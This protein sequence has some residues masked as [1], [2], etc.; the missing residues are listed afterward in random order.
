MWE[1][2]SKKVLVRFLL[3]PLFAFLFVL[4]LL[5]ERV[6][7][8][9]FGSQ[10]RKENQTTPKPNGVFVIKASKVEHAFKTLCSLTRFFN[11]PHRYPIRIFVDTVHVS[12]TQIQTLESFAGGADVRVIADPEQRW[13]KLPEYFTDQQKQE[14][15]NQCQDFENPSIAKCTTINAPLGYVYMIYWNYAVMPYE[16]ELR[17]YDY[18]ISLDTDTFLTRPIFHLDPF[19][20]MENNNLIGMFVIEAFEAGDIARGVQESVEK[21][22]DISQRANKSLG[23]R[24]WFDE[25]GVWNSAGLHKYKPSVWTH[26]WGG[27]RDFF[28]S[29]LYREFSRHMGYYTYLNRA[30]EQAVIGAAWALLG[31]A[32]RIWYLP[33]KGIQLGVYHHGWVDNQEL[34]KANDS[35]HYEVNTFHK[36]NGFREHRSKTLSWERYLQLTGHGDGFNTC[37]NATTK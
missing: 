34:L 14:I 37:S 31:S 7:V 30:D 2:R 29:N 19:A 9:Q 10:A 28:E 27:R 33:E 24:Q 16:S 35:N 26:F 11:S 3:L 1:K 12:T 6:V 17:A 23:S 25:N 5:V 22:F 13:T 32:D 15:L 36:W 18:I 8:A 21:V 20:I 4:W